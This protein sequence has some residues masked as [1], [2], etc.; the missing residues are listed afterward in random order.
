MRVG[1]AR[2]FINLV[3]NYFINT[4]TKMTLRVNHYLASQRWPF[5]PHLPFLPHLP[6]CDFSLILRT[7]KNLTGKYFDDMEV[8][9][10]ALLRAMDA[11]KIE[12][13]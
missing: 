4:P 7:K 9:K 6:M 13:F 8:V 12:A 11:N 10:T 2:N 3:T 1:K 5:V